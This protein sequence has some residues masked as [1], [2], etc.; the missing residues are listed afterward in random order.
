MPA[1]H[2]LMYFIAGLVFGVSL[3]WGVSERSMVI[4][5][6]QLDKL[7]SAII[8]SIDSN[9]SENNQLSSDYA[10]P[11]IST[12]SIDVSNSLIEKLKIELTPVIIDELNVHQSEILA[13][14][15]NGSQ[16]KASLNEQQYQQYYQAQ[17]MLNAIGNGSQMTLDQ[18]VSD[19][20]V[21]NLPDALKKKL[22]GEVAMK[23]TSGELN[24]EE[25]LG[26]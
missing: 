2:S 5:D 17:S 19:S 10:S 12:D 25:F 11:I 20:S 14:I 26:K 1:Q 22:M 3:M 15:N 8:K 21:A 24:P 23:L 7:S 6:E 9:S 4:P 13:A 16:K 18:F